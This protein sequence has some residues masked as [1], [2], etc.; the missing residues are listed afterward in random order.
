MDAV[1]IAPKV[2]AAAAAALIECAGKVLRLNPADVETVD[3]SVSF[4][5]IELPPT[6][7]GAASY[8]LGQQ[9]VTI[10]INMK[11]GARASWIG[12]E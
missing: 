4:D 6:R 8:E 3:F 10:T 11:P 2:T 7:T 12:K 5:K 9:H 1:D